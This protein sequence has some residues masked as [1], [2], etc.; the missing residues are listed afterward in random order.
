L[1]CCAWWLGCHINIE[2]IKLRWWHT[3]LLTWTRVSSTM[4]HTRAVLR[5]CLE[6]TKRR[7][8]GNLVIW[9]LLHGGG[10]CHA[11]VIIMLRVKHV[12]PGSS[13]HAHYQMCS[14][15]IRLLTTHV[16]SLVPL[17]TDLNASSDRALIE[18]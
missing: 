11:K 8:K 16:C 2:A 10:R 9:W 17:N 7:R 4:L 12:T 14:R 5:R 13:M 3:Y 15:K 6:P 1:S 18:P